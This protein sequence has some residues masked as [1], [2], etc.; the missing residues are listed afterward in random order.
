MHV[1]IA[2]FTVNRVINYVMS[3]EAAQ[4]SVLSTKLRGAQLSLFPC[5]PADVSSTL[6]CAEKS[7]WALSALQS[8]TEKSTLS[9]AFF[10]THASCS[11]SH[12]ARDCYQAS[13]SVNLILFTQ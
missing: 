2:L 12:R 8:A 3:H 13:F 11:L 7:L 1:T 4:R 9:V 6:F 5:L 10:H